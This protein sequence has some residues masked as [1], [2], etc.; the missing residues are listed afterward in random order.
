MAQN[1]KL[2]LTNVHKQLYIE[3]TTNFVLFIRISKTTLPNL[4][5]V[6]YNRQLFFR[7]LGRH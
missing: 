4:N 3:V 5:Y 1:L 6:H 7:N 2:V